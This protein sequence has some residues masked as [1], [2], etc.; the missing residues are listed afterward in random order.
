MTP[1]Y[2]L[3]DILTTDSREYIGVVTRITLETFLNDKK[4]QVQTIKYTIK[5]AGRFYA[6]E[7]QD[8]FFLAEAA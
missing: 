8:A 2:K 7:E 6:I 1:K 5:A 3:N 4:E